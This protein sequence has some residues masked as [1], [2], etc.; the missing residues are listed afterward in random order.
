[1]YRYAPN[2]LQ[3]TVRHKIEAITLLRYYFSKI[4]VDSMIAHMR[5]RKE[6]K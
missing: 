1:M 5:V 2:R 3:K 4:T 6:E